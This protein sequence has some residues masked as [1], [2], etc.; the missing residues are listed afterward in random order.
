M[1]VTYFMNSSFSNLANP[2]MSVLLTSA[3]G[4]TETEVMDKYKQK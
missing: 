4:C 2:L 3:N 1:T